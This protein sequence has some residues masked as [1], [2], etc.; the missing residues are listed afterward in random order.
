L[1]KLIV[2]TF[3]LFILSTF[4]FTIYYLLFTNEGL[5]TELRLIKKDI[6]GTLTIKSVEGSLFSN[7]K[8]T[9]IYYSSAKNNSNINSNIHIKTLQI[10]WSPKEL[11]REK[12]YI[13][14]I[15]LN[16]ADVVITNLPKTNE[17]KKSSFTIPAWLKYLKINQ[18]TINQLKLKINN[19]EIKL[20]GKITTKWDITWQA[21]I[22]NIQD[23]IPDLK[24]KIFADGKITGNLLRP[25]I[26]NTINIKQ[27][28]Y[29]QQKIESILIKSNITLKPNEQSH[30]S[31]FAKNLIIKDQPI[32]S[33][34]FEIDGMFIRNT[35]NLQ[36]NLTI[37]RLRLPPLGLTLKNTKINANLNKKNILSI[38]SETNSGSGSLQIVGDINLNQINAPIKLTLTG[39]KF[40]IINSNEYQIAA[41]P[42]L[43]INIIQN[44]IN[45]NGDILIPNANIQLKNP[46]ELVTLSD[47]VVFASYKKEKNNSPFS[48][49]LQI[50]L[51]LGENIHIAY[52]NLETNLAGHIQLKQVPNGALTAIGQLN[53]NRG[54]Y[55]AYGQ[56]LTIE[57]GHLIYTGGLLINPGINIVAVKK[58]RSVNLSTG[59]S[60]FSHS[61]ELQPIYTG[62]QSLTIGIR[63]TGSLS[64]PV[65]SFFSD[66]SLEQKDIISYLAFGY[67]SSQISQHQMGALFS[68]V[69]A[70]GPENKTSVTSITNKLEKSLGFNEFNLGST[71]VFD[72]KTSTTISTTTVLIGK[73]L[74]PKLSLHYRFGIFYP[75]SILNLRYQLGKYWAIQSETSTIDNGADVLFSIDRD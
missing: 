12:L 8:L 1:I 24:G 55:L 36:V 44:Q 2:R 73:Q 46:N 63:V 52:E 20:T 56:P 18:L 7:F 4:G 58:L 9:D 25:D 74:A 70:F 61:T 59:S 71:E 16:K 26:N 22:K 31:F 28:S 45:I 30:I 68:M 38:N 53:A 19:N 50:N 42:N 51:T 69:S 15:L 17:N 39:K 14:N 66:P 43:T 32:K 60:Q 72:P 33:S 10:S 27:F 40:K 57:T 29:Q 65:V 11:L 3:L 5:K 34:K 75:I 21:N 67:P 54:T 64:Q 49:G 6:P 48:L 62:T 35:Q 13:N 41:S 47:D 23:L 37:S